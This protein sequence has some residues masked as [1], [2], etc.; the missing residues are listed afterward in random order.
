LTSPPTPLLKGE[1]SKVRKFSIFVPHL[2]PGEGIR[3]EGKN[4]EKKICQN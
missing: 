4:Q 2:P 3:G 1:G